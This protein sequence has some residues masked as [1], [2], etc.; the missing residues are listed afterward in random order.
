ME[1]CLGRPPVRG[2]CLEQGPPGGLI[3]RKRVPK[4]ELC[5][6]GAQDETS[7]RSGSGAASGRRVW[8]LPAEGARRDVRTEGGAHTPARAPRGWAAGGA[9]PGGREGARGRAGAGGQASRSGL[10]TAGGAW[11]LTDPAR[12]ATPPPCH[13]GKGLRG[14]ARSRGLRPPAMA[15]LGTCGEGPG[16]TRPP[17]NHP[18]SASLCWEG[19]WGAPNTPCGHPEGPAGPEHGCVGTTGSRVSVMRR[20]CPC[21]WSVHGP[22][23]FCE[24]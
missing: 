6:E 5:G 13:P 10:R 20:H 19:G 2:F 18:W 9:R 11:N 7:G 24:W 14:P 4:W 22:W 16:P 15:A 23:G 12:P 1:G 21:P 3:S 17:Y 8:P